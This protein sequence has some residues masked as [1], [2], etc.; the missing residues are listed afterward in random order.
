MTLKKNHKEILT[1]KVIT[2]HILCW[3]FFVTY[4]ISLLNS[5]AQKLEPAYT[6]LIYY[7]L[8][9]S[10]FYGHVAILNFAFNRS[11]PKY[12]RGAFLFF[13]L[14]LIYL[15]LK[16]Y[17]SYLLQTPYLS[18]RI[19]FQ[20]F[21]KYFSSTLWRLGYFTILSTFY[22]AAGHISYFR[23]QAATAEKQELLALKDKAEVETRLA[24]AN[25]AYLAQQINPHLLFNSLSFIYSSVIPYSDAAAKCVLLV[26]DLMR[27]SLEETGPDGKVPLT[28]EISQ[29]ECL[30][31]INRLRFDKPPAIEVLF[32]GDFGQY[33]IIPLILFTLTENIIKHGKLND[34]SR[35]ALLRISTDEQGSLNYFSRNL[36]KSK[37]AYAQR[38]QVGLQ[39]VHIRLDFAY[40][41]KYSLD[42]TDNTEFYEISLNLSL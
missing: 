17:I 1:I 22:W 33:R 38:R 37:S 24:E 30:L 28:D 25:N 19:Y 2:L 42:I 20:N 5:V 34:V 12:I 16:L 11:D 18:L 27:F 21:I 6:Y 3:F 7:C 13:T 31:E 4:E 41:G 10:Y 14:I 8:N 40:P 26:T 36:K 32:E 15:V 23:K 35:P 9:I 39:N 29:I